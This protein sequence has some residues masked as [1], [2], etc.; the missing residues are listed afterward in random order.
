[1]TGR[2]K[3]NLKKL[4]KDKNLSQQQIANELNIKRSTYSNWESGQVMPSV[5]TL[6]KICDTFGVHISQLLDDYNHFDI[7]LDL[8]RDNGKINETDSDDKKGKI[9]GKISG[10]IDLL[11]EKTILSED[12]EQLKERLLKNDEGELRLF[13]HMLFMGLQNKGL[14]INIKHIDKM[15]T[16]FLVTKAMQLTEIFQKIDLIKEEFA[17][18]SAEIDKKLKQN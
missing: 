9:K 3:E 16:Y 13:I 14:K 2:L 5:D 8:N 7:F 12:F 17:S 6:R 15:N 4:R 1:M 18:F 11:D 10:K